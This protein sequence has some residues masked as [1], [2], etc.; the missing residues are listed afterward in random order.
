M[1]GK[2]DVKN[3]SNS[4]ELEAAQTNIIQLKEELSAAISQR[5]Q[6]ENSIQQNQQQVFNSSYFRFLKT[7]ILLFH[8]ILFIV[9]FNVIINCNKF[10]F[11]HFTRGMK[12]N[13][14]PKNYCSSSSQCFKMNSTL[15]AGSTSKLKINIWMGYGIH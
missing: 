2:T 14:D 1:A 9:F 13:L 5:D 7:R 10:D 4:K 11:A 15:R 12:L 8:M 3:G 6:M